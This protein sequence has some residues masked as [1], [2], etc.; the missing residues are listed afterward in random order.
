MTNPTAPAELNITAH[1]A[2]AS[3][4][5]RRGWDGTPEPLAISRW[6]VGIAGGVVALEGLR[7][8]SVKGT[9]LAGAGTAIAW[10][11]FTGEGDLSCVRQRLAGLVDRVAAGRAD[12][13]VDASL[14]S[15]PASDPP[16][17]TAAVG[18]GT[19]RQAPRAAR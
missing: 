7:Q 6:L 17:Y 2:A 10:W 3:V 8:R 1:R 14:D 9:M 15:F 11:A 4:W 12:K 5:D 13:I 16:A 18:V 19:R